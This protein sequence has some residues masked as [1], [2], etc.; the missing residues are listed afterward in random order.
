MHIDRGGFSP[1]A[2]RG[3]LLAAIVMVFA[4]QIA[5]LAPLAVESDDVEPVSGLGVSA[6]GS[7]PLRTEGH[8]RNDKRQRVPGQ[9][10]VNLGGGLPGPLIGKTEAKYVA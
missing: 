9:A 5:D 8:G 4:H 3:Y 1:E 6:E 7:F 10:G 2:A